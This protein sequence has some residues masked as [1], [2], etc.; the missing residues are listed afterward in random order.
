[1]PD[2]SRLA[3]VFPGRSAALRASGLSR[4]TYYD[5]PCGQVEA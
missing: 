2:A 1:M 3:A 4:S 5:E